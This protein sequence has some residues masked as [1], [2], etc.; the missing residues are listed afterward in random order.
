MN[1]EPSHFWHAVSASALAKS[2]HKGIW[3]LWYKN[4]GKYLYQFCARPFEK[5]EEEEEEE[6]EDGEIS[7]LAILHNYVIVAMYLTTFES[8]I[9]YRN[10]H[11]P[12][13]ASK[14]TYRYS[15]LTYFA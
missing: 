6:E 9:V 10:T 11:R 3:S 13:Y 15:L 14:R 12:W 5:E 1:A 8:V 4:Q 2:L 7:V